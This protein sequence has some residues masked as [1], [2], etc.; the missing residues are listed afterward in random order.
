MG[1]SYEVAPRSG[2][3]LKMAQVGAVTWTCYEAVMLGLHRLDR[4]LAADVQSLS[5]RA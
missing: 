1:L 5:E 4:K 3:G 2:S